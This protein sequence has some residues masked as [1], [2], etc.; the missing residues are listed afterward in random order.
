MN[1]VL[2]TP[3]GPSLW[4][5]EDGRK[6]IPIVPF[7][8]HWQ[9]SGTSRNEH[10]RTQIPLRLAWA[11]T[12]HKSQGLTLGDGA[13]IALGSKEFSTGLTFVALSRVRTINDLALIETVDYNRV[14]NLGGKG[15]T[16]DQ[17]RQDK[18][19]RYNIGANVQPDGIENNML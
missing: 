14:K 15:D 4:H 19:R 1:T 3:L 11:I 12:V 2:T 18:R 10:T 17:R 7:K 8:T 13:R 9:P 16:M 6:L 5:T